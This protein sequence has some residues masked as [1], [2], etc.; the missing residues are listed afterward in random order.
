MNEKGYF[1]LQKLI[2]NQQNDCI[3]YVVTA[4]DKGVTKVKRFG[5]V[6]DKKMTDVLL[7]K[8][9][10]VKFEYFSIRKNMYAMKWLSIK[11]Y[12]HFWKGLTL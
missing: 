10:D 11:S 1:V 5:S 6:T 2:L 4:R 9:R 3:E 12:T 7:D 8:P